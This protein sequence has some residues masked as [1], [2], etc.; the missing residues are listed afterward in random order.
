LDGVQTT[1]IIRQKYPNSWVYIVSMT[2]NAFPGKCQRRGKY[3][4]VRR[5]RVE[6]VKNGDKCLFFI[7]RG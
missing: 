2:A 6:T 5:G 4:R 3:E 7:I 1:K